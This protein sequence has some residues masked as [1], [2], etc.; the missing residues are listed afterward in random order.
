METLPQVAR[1]EI[2]K[3]GDQQAYTVLVRNEHNVTVY[4][5]TLMFSGLW[6]GDLPKP[7]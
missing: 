7:D 4:T 5:A 1:D 6:V 3:D 2:P